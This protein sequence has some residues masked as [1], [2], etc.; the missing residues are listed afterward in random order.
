MTRDELFKQMVDFLDQLPPNSDVSITKNKPFLFHFE[1]SRLLIVRDMLLNC[2]IKPDEKF[3]ILDFGYLH[4]LFQEFVHRFF[5][6]AHLTV[7]DRPDSTIFQD[8]EYQ[9]LIGKRDYLKLLPGDINEFDDTMG[10]YRVIFLGEIVEHLNPT[11]VV[12]LLQKF[13]KSIS[14]GGTLLIT[15]PNAAGLYNCYITVRNKGRVQDPPIPMPLVGMGHIHLWSETLLRQT[16]EFAGWK[17]KEIKF[18]HGRE[19]EIFEKIP[20]FNISMRVIKF[21]ADRKPRLRGFFVATFL[22]E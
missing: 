20:L 6:K 12:E 14:P 7:F 19:G 8:R 4:G 1:A 18:Y 9:S 16:A 22:A 5:P 11:D 15:T 3:E 2:G 17:F 13:R 10:P 21:L